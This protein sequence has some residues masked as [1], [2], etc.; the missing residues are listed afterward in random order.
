MAVMFVAVSAVVPSLLIIWYVHARDV[1]R[2]PAKVLWATFGF[3]VLTIPAVLITVIPLASVMGIERIQNAIVGGLLEA[4]VHAAIP[5][6]FFKFAV[7]YF[8]CMRH[9]EFDEPMDGIVYGVAASLGF[10]TLENI[11][12]VFQ[13]GI[14]VA[15]LRAFTAVPGHACCG[16]IMGYF[17]GQAAFRPTERGKLLS[18]ALGFP[19]LVHALYDFP[20]MALSRMQKDGRTLRSSEETLGMALL[21]LFLVVLTVEV[22]WAYRLTAR[23]R[24]EQVRQAYWAGAANNPH[25]PAQEAVLDAMKP[26]TRGSGWL[27]VLPGALFATVGGLIAL[28]IA[29]G[30]TF[31][32]NTTEE[33]KGLIV[34]ALVLGVAPL[35]LGTWLFASGMKRLNAADR[36]RLYAQAQGHPHAVPR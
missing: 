13:G 29:L 12:Y 24:G 11:L 34:G 2:E 17:A 22:V 9:R 20:L 32:D 5:E 23:L 7:L 31:G 6:E 19:I 36:A 30:L 26:P 1:Y 15:V 18:A 16:A 28:G 21:L 33:L 4:F 8:Y 27:R 35:A 14:G 25:H 10:A 3:G